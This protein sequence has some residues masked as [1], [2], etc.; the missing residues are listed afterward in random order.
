VEAH[1]PHHAPPPIVPVDGGLAHNDT[2]D[3]FDDDKVD[4]K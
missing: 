1:F 4:A 3:E 2:E